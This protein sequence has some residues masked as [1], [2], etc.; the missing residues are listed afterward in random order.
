MIVLETTSKR[1]KTTK[2]SVDMLIKAMFIVMKFVRGEIEADW[3]LHHEEF[4][5]MI[6]YFFTIMHAMVCVIR[7]RLKHSQAKFSFA[8]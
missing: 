7:D 2:L 8:S 4:R 5:V 1:S 3:L 6:P